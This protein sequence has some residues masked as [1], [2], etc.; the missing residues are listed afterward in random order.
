[1]HQIPRTATLAPRSEWPSTSHKPLFIYHHDTANQPTSVLASAVDASPGATTYAIVACAPTLCED[2]GDY[3]EQT[4]IQFNRT[5]WIGASSYSSPAG[6]DVVEKWACYIDPDGRPAGPDNQPA[7]CVAQTAT[8]TLTAAGQLT[9]DWSALAPV[10]VDEC[11]VQRRMVAAVITAGMDKVYEVEGYRD[12]GSLD[13]MI[14]SLAS[15][16]CPTRGPDSMVTLPH[17]DG[18]DEE[19]ASRND[20]WGWA[21]SES[22]QRANI[23][24]DHME[25][26][27]T[28]LGFGVL[29]ALVTS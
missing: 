8:G 7:W 10:G 11:F 28:V 21:C 15:A 4:V 24:G 27:C 20:I 23:F 19:G 5:V 18:R 13:D 16:P 26:L 17:L 14:D 2:G 12:P 22:N 25:T 29:A 9:G 1:M 6:D 3:P